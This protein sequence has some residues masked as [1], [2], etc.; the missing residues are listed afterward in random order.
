ME[1]DS[2]NVDVEYNKAMNDTR[3]DKGVNRAPTSYKLG[4]HIVPGIRYW[5]Q[6]KSFPFPGN[7]FLKCHILNQRG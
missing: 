6:K 2:I 4:E 3:T 1:L 5:G 7:S